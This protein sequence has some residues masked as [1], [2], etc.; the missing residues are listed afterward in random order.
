MKASLKDIP[1][2]V[3]DR[4]RKEGRLPAFEPKRQTTPTMPDKAVE[5]LSIWL[6]AKWRNWCLYCGIVCTG[7]LG[8]AIT[9]GIITLI[10]LAR[11]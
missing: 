6:L 7:L 5:R 8:M 1:E 2:D 3:Q 9:S 11:K 4:L 10:W